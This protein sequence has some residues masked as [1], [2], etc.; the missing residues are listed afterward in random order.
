MPS[1]PVLCLPPGRVDPKVLELNVL[2]YHSQPGGSW[3]TRRSLPVRWWS[4]H[5]GDDTVVVLLW[6]WSSQVPVKPQSECTTNQELAYTAASSHLVFTHQVAAL[7]CIIWCQ[8][9]HLKRVTSNRGK[10]C[11][12]SSQSNLKRRSL[13]RLGSGWWGFAATRTT[14]WVEIWDQFLI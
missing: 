11:Q 2:I 10:P 13:R 6:S 9:C 4:Q 3:T 1:I 14:R 5:G 12:I 7:F 8:Y